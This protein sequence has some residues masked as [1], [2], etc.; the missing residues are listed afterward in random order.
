MSENKWRPGEVVPESSNYTAY[1]KDGQDGG[2]CYL[3]KGERF[4]ATQHSG[5]YYVKEEE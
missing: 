2:S 4:P 1:D 5:S 3:E